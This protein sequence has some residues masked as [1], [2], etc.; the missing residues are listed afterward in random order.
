MRNTHFNIRCTRISGNHF[1]QWECFQLNWLGISRYGH[2]RQ[3]K[4]SSYW[5]VINIVFSRFAQI[6]QRKKL[7]FE[8]NWPLVTQLIS[9]KILFYSAENLLRFFLLCTWF[10]YYFLFFFLK[11][12]FDT[13]YCI[14]VTRLQEISDIRCEV[15]YINYQRIIRSDMVT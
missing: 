6:S 9:K 15:T 11:L 10:F 14:N 3:F 2:F 13:C 4:R 5:I 8:E 12:S 1:V 7:L